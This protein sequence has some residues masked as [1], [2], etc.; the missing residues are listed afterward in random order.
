[1][2][3]AFHTPHRGNLDIYL[4]FVP[5]AFIVTNCSM[6]LRFLP[7]SGAKHVLPVKTQQ[8][9]QEKTHRDTVITEV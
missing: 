8:L 1:M 2:E 9:H 7:G 5:V 3:I 6:Q 4:Y